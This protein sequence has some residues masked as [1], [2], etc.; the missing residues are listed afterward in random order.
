MKAVI[1][2]R[3]A[4]IESHPLHLTDAPTP[5]PRADELLVRVAACG[6]CRS[7]LHMIEGDWIAAGV[8]ARSPI[9]PG[10][11]I[12]GTVAALG[13]G[14]T[15]FAVGARVGIQPLWSSCG[16]CEYCLT[17]REPLCDGK[18]ITG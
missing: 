1:L 18:Q 4:P 9:I 12:V 5:E 6:V 8:P 7:N 16:R 13:E 17:G 10:H 11:E 2:E 14:V 15:T 3:P